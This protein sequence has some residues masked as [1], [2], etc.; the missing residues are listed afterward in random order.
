MKRMIFIPLAAT[1]LFAAGCSTP[2]ESTTA[3]PPSETSATSKTVSTAIEGSWHGRDVT[4]G[5]DGPASLII[6]GQTLE[7]HGGDTDDWAKGTFTL[8]EDTTP[9]QL[10]GVI[11]DCAS[12]DNI[13]KKCYAIYKVENGTLTLTGSQIGAPNPPPSFDAPECRQMVFKHD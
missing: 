8:R 3:A 13:G 1:A 4:P 12:A 11:T 5:H 9:K 6:S 7:F 10:I 2:S